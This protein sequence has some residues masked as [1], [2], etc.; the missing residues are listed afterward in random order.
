MIRGEESTCQCR[1]H[2]RRAFD[3]WAGKIPLEEERQPTPVFLPG[4][5]QG[6]WSLKGYSP[7][8]CKELDMTEQLS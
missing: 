8:C 6:K 5:F 4:K 3:P 1:R 7:W 2:R